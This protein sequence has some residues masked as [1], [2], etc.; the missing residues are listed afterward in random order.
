MSYQSSLGFLEHTIGN[1][2]TDN[3]AELVNWKTASGGELLKGDFLFQFQL[4][5]DLKSPYYMKS[6]VDKDLTP[7]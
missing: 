2:Y 1:G 6:S 4:L 5:S 7:I 3:S